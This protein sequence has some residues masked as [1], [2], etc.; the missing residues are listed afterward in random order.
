[1]F[2]SVVCRANELCTDGRWF[3]V[4]A[5]CIGT[6]F[7]AYLFYPAAASALDVSPSNAGLISTTIYFYQIVPLVMSGHGDSSTL[8][9]QTLS[10]VAN[11]QLIATRSNWTLWSVLSH[12]LVLSFC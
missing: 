3:F 9:S 2:G 7:A 8:L 5:L 12:H 6:L 10:S 1:M 4:V 11:L